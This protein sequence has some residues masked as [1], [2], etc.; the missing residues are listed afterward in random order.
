MENHPQTGQRLAYVDFLKML[1]LL[2]IMLAHSDPPSWL[3]EVRN[4][5]VP[6]M[7]ILSSLLVGISYR[8]IPYSVKNSFIYVLQRIKKLVIPTHIFLLFYFFVLFILGYRYPPSY[9]FLSFS[10]TLYGIAFVWVILIYIYSSMLIPLF[11]KLSIKQSIM[12]IVP[13]YLLYE[14]LFHYNV[15]TNN[16]F[17][18]STIYYIVPYGVL[19]FLGLIYPLIPK[20]VKVC[21]IIISGFV[22]LGTTVYYFFSTDTFLSMQS[23]KY[24]PRYYYLSYGI[25]VS[26]I[27]L[28]LTE[29]IKLS[30][31]KNK[32]II[33]I[34]KHSL[35]IYLWH[36]LI[37]FI[38]E[39]TSISN[40][41]LFKWILFFVGSSIIVL[42]QNVV[43]SLFEK[44]FEL[45]LFK[46][47]KY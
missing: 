27:L 33:F 16:R 36:I 5:D 35:W 2:C 29:S 1:G 43:I 20:S 3:F 26:F 30:L 44:H 45:P 40:W 19:T 46:Y 38:V 23:L 39:Q 47:F 42:V 18:L 21:I 13:V 31:Y 14:L 37:V 10:L 9:Y 8:K 24:P 17:I 34:S 6:L 7:V 12:L 11:T 25:F 32:L 4:F 41:W 15:G 28:V 22:Y